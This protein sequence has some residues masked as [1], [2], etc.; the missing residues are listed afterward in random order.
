[1]HDLV[2]FLRLA[3]LALFLNVYLVGMCY[4]I[5]LYAGATH[6]EALPSDS[7]STSGPELS[8]SIWSSAGGSSLTEI[9]PLSSS[10]ARIDLSPMT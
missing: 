7:L 10:G 6:I 9:E 2:D 1:M 8:T 4:G 3:T 5:N